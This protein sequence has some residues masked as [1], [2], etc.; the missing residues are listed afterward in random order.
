MSMPW[1]LQPT[2]Q[3]NLVLRSDIEESSARADVGRG[4]ND[5]CICVKGFVA[6]GDFQLDQGFRRE[7]IHHVEVTAVEALSSP[8]REETRSVVL[9]SSI[10]AWAEKKCRVARRRSWS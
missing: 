9:G 1:L 6:G 2:F 8:T 5:S 10:S 7:R 3:Q 4:V